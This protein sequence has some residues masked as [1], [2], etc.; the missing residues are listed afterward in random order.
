M[1]ARKARL[2]RREEVGQSIFGGFGR[3]EDASFRSTGEYVP[4]TIRYS[5][6]NCRRP[7]NIPKRS[8]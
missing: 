2:V 1:E 5:Y 3:F 8:C 4:I 6:G 7:Q